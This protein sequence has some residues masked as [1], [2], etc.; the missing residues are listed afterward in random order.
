MSELNKHRQTKEYKLSDQ[1]G[2][3]TVPYKGAEPKAYKDIAGDP[4]LMESVKKMIADKVVKHLDDAIF[5]MVCKEMDNNYMF[6]SDNYL[7]EA[8]YEM[9]EDQWF[10][11][12]HEHHGDILAQIHNKLIY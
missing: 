10:E 8:G 6:R 7:T 12:Y 9:F 4:D 11:F 2:E 5:E 1:G 3:Y